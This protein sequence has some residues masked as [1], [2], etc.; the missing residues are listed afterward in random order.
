MKKRRDEKRK[1]ER[2]EK[3][4]REKKQAARDTVASCVPRNNPLQAGGNNA[5]KMLQHQNIISRTYIR[6]DFNS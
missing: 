5:Q 2:K 6:Y 4:G 1:K 3:N